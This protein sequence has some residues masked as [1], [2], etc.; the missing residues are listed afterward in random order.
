MKKI[1]V[2]CITLILTFI[3]ALSVSAE[4]LPAL[5]PA[6]HIKTGITEQEVASLLKTVPHVKLHPAE[7]L[8]TG[9]TA[10][11]IAEHYTVCEISHTTGESIGGQTLS[12]TSYRLAPD[13]STHG[14]ALLLIEEVKDAST[15][16]T[17][18]FTLHYGDFDTG[19]IT[20]AEV[21]Y[22]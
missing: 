17:L 12:V 9:L 19:E 1:V 18:Y 16:E 2:P 21:V 6:E 22:P 11:T 10:E 7:K 5:H 3:L 15:H 20:R 4:S 13:E 14:E 8:K